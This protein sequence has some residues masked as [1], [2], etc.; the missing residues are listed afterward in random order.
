[1][2]R[3]RSRLWNIPISCRRFVITSQKKEDAEEE[4]KGNEK[5]EESIVSPQ[6]G[7]G[8]RY[9]PFFAH[10]QTEHQL[11]EASAVIGEDEQTTPGPLRYVSVIQRTPLFRPREP[12]AEKKREP[13]Q[14]SPKPKKEPEGDDM[15]D[16]DDTDDEA[17]LPVQEAPIDYHV[18]RAKSPESIDEP[19]RP[20]RGDVRE[21]PA[22]S[23]R[24][25]R[26]AAD[27]G[28]IDMR[29]VRPRLSASPKRR[30]GNHHDGKPM[31]GDNG[32][33]GGG[34]G[35]GGGNNGG[36]G[37]YNN[38]S[39]GRSYQMGGSGGGGGMSGFGGGSDSGNGGGNDNHLPYGDGSLPLDGCGNEF[40]YT[41]LE[42][43]GPLPSLNDVLPSMRSF[44]PSLYAR[45]Q[46]PPRY[47]NPPDLDRPPGGGGGVPGS[48]SDLEA[49][50]TSLTS[51]TNLNPFN[52]NLNLYGNYSQNAYNF[53][54]SGHG[55]PVTAAHTPN[56]GGGPSP[57][58]GT[59]ADLF[60][61]ANDPDM[62]ADDQNSFCP[63]VDQITGL[64]LS[65]P[66]ESGVHVMP[67]HH[68]PTQQ[69]QQQ[70]QQQD[71]LY[72]HQAHDQ[73]HTRV[74]TTSPG[75]Y[76]N[77][78]QSHRRGGSPTDSDGL[79]GLVN[80]SPSALLT[81]LSI[82][83]SPLMD[84][85]FGSSQ[86][87]PCSINSSSS[88]VPHC[89]SSGG[90][91]NRSLHAHTPA[92]QQ[93]QQQQANSNNNNNNNN[94][95]ISV[96]QSDNESV[97]NLQVRVSVLQQRDISM[98]LGLSNDVPIEFVNGGHGIKNPLVHDND[99]KDS[100]R[101]GF[102]SDSSSR[103]QIHMKSSKRGSGAGGRDGAISACSS[104]TA[105]DGMNTGA[106]PD[107]PNKFTCRLCSKSF[108]LQR[109]LN[110]H[111]KCHS[112]VKRYLCTFCG[113]GFNDTFDLKRHT[114]THTGVRPYKCALC[115][116]SFTQRCS[117]ESHCLKVHGVA[118]QYQYKERRA[119]VYVCE[120]CG[121][122]T[123]EPEVHYV[124]LKE[125]HPYSPALLKFYD[126]R[127]FKFT[128]NNF[129]NMLLQVRS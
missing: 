54:N 42:Q 55:G 79:S 56:S 82:D 1:M 14:P 110:R 119:K 90:L 69:Q 91:L 87:S 11:P 129:T 92:P 83:Q 114:R 44:H 61:L 46:E 7:S 5:E 74:Y 6:R 117:L 65:F 107:D 40:D 88:P 24:R 64:Q 9:L 62:C 57:C 51:L 113:K 27:N 76:S 60:E 21:T 108:T 38:G 22:S 15:P 8:R 95:V 104:S 81:P 71:R 109:L 2:C 111:M 102:E 52:G 58:G 127:H 18:P 33:G 103:T 70:Q 85:Q 16:E 31:D 84:V 29:C 48:N 96:D 43:L 80:F 118:H 123:N 53:T 32:C 30:G 116:K 121:H 13:P 19:E 25:A 122:T 93:H 115:E 37:G 72:H 36:G 77:V 26:E 100:T 4:V 94:S 124:H 78:S 120:E 39:S 128:N 20:H 10:L 99:G 75:G 68:L 50:L 35:G 47:A 73:Q 125:L 66:V 112:D 98:Q 59:Q 49:T 67:E 34:N 12:D 23:R 17:T 97:S 89:E 126:K 86:M 101:D 28:A 105:A 3:R 63:D 45:L 41:R 106:D